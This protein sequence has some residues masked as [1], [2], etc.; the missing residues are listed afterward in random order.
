MANTIRIKRRASGAAG[1]P[2]SLL[3]AELA[4]NEVDNTLYYG[5]G[6]T[7]GTATSILAIGGTG[8]FVGLT[9]DQTIAGTKTFSS[10]IVGNLTGT[11]S[12]ATLAASATTATSATSATNAAN[13]G[14]T[15][16][17][18][19]ATAVYPTW[20]TA[21]T[22]NLPNKVS[23]TKL[24]FVPSTGVLTA[25]GF[26]GP[27]TG[28]VTGNLTGTASNATLAASA[29]TA[30]S[31]TNTT[32][33]GVTEDVATATA[34]YPTWVTANTG[35]LPNKVSSTKLSFVPSTGILTATGFSGPLTGNVTGTASNATLAASATK[36][37]TARNLVINGDGSATLTS[38]DGTANVT[39]GLTLATVNTAVGT[40]GSA[41]SIPVVTVNGKGLVTNV[42]TA[43]ISTSLGV[44]GDS[45][46]DTLALGTDTFTISGG[47]GLTSVMNS[48][49]NTLTVNADLASTSALGVASFD[50]GDFAVSTAGVVTVKAGGIDNSQLANTA[51]TIGSTAIA[52]G[53]TVTTIT[54]LANPVNDSDAATK[55][56]V[57]SAIQGLDP[58]QS[59]RAASTAN[60]A[61][62]SGTMTIDGV[63]LIA[64]DRVL[65]KDQSTSSQNGIYVV[66]AGAWSRALDANTWAEL[67]SAYVLVEEGT[68][69]ADSG[70]ICTVNQGGT[71]DSTAV[72]FVQFTGAGQ[73]TAGAG[74]T[75]TGNTIDIATASTAR[76][77][78]NADSI[79]LATVGTAGTYRSV[80]TDAYGRVTAGTNPTTLSGYGITDAQPLDA[81]LTALAGVTT[82]AN[83]LIYSTASDTFTTTS[84]T[85]F[86]RTILD[87]ADASTARTTLGLV[88]GTDVQ[89][90]SANL[91]TIAGLAVTDG[92]FIVGNG[93]TWVVESGATVRTSLGL[94]TIATQN[95]NAVTIT[96][97]SIDG[98]TFDGGTF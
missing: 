77:V 59:V 76:I 94:G 31:A 78:V 95:A 25:T 42:T 6:D 70:Y 80:T 68:V 49:T 87:D 55:G 3:N 24:S 54:G 21:N 9:G 67:I 50:S 10:A 52:L 69:N 32:N 43:A 8:A 30:T 74:L 93:T 51:V 75:K 40:Y 97:G 82:A 62:L 11:A 7:G 47:T 72:T 35:N 65:V 53:G 71:L 91:A 36:W 23:S 57:D 90:Y 58:K 84:L 83:Q 33:V 20:V 19:T 66:S 38:V 81:T 29:T 88:I 48:T 5:K 86:A 28:N 79:D 60:I 22:G 16:D 12:N 13:V 44:A 98:I 26:S 1:A 39:A 64:G 56:Y 45:G 18:A 61:T 63:A 96:G 27:L 2:A 14:V 46:T 4:F 15:E 73:I 37:A 17:V 85:A 89:A 41:T 34:V 92:N